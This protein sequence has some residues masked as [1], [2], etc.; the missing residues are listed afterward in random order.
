V[1][2]RQANPEALDALDVA[3]AR[4]VEVIEADLLALVTDRINM[5]LRD[6]D[7]S[8]VATT[9]LD[10]AVCAVVDQ[11]LVDVARMDDAT[12]EHAASFFPDGAFADL[13]MASYIIEARTRLSMA[14]D[15]LLG[16]VG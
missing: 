9:D 12:V 11:M 1:T 16:G 13:V 7:P 8:C 14:A 15:R 4:A 2:L 5:A 3:Y 10:H 6:A